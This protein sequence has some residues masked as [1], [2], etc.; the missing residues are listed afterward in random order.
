ML[1]FLC[2]LAHPT[3]Y[4]SRICRAEFVGALNEYAPKSKGFSVM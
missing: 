4:Q 2:P 3:H 1:D